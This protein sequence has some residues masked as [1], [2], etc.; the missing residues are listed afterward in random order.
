MSE[1]YLLLQ[2]TAVSARTGMSTNSSVEFFQKEGSKVFSIRSGKTQMKIGVTKQRD[3]EYPEDAWDTMVSFYE[4]SGYVPIGDKKVEKLSVQSGDKKFVPISDKTFLPVLNRMVSAND[5]MIEELFSKSV[6]DVPDERIQIVQ[7]TL[8]E[9]VRAG[10]KMPVKEFNN[11]LLKVVWTQIPRAQNQLCEKLAKSPKDYPAIIQR[12]QEILDNLVQLL[13]KARK[14]GKT[15]NEVTDTILSA[16]GLFERP[17]TAE[18]KKLLKDLMTDKSSMYVRAWRTGSKEQDERFEQC[19]KEHGYTEENGGVQYLFHGTGFSNIWSIW[20]NGLYLN[21]EVLKSN[22]RICGKAFGYGLYFAPYIYKSMGD[23]S[24][25]F[26]SG[27]HAHGYMLVFK[28]MTGNP[29][30]IYRDKNPKR[31]NHWKDFHR[32]HPDMDCCWAESGSSNGAFMRLRWD[33]VIVYREE[34]AAL[35]YVIEYDAA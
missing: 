14:S 9:M 27:R 13:N 23:C 18:E 24:N 25:D 17:V 29:Y 8:I 12:E 30:Y 20:T 7:Q 35:Q 28:V 21:P 32:D 31:P 11:K 34:Q 26:G 19:C 6:L 2:K 4:N 3:K 33:E 16:N 15:E 10:D 22:V 5:A 1:R